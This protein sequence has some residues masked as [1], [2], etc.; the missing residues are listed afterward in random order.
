MSH[1]HR[2]SPHPHIEPVLSQPQALS[3]RAVLDVR[4]HT[5]QLP[6]RLPVEEQ[7]HDQS[8]Y[9]LSLADGTC[10]LKREDAARNPPERRTSSTISST[11]QSHKEVEDATHQGRRTVL[12]ECSKTR[13][14]TR[15]LPVF[16]GK[17]LTIKKKLRSA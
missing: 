9:L 10:A 3:Q 12:P 11:S 17:I 5:A 4:R 2:H 1:Y 16:D 6:T 15:S 7:L 13:K 8:D 14:R